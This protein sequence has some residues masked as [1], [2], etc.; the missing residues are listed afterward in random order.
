MNWQKI[1]KDISK[2][3]NS[4]NFTPLGIF[5]GIVGLCSICLL[6]IIGG[7]NNLETR[8]EPVSTNRIAPKTEVKT[9]SVQV[10]FVN[11]NGELLRQIDAEVADTP[12]ERRVGLMNREYLAPDKGMLFIFEN[13]SV[14]QFWMKNTLI[15]LDIIFISEQ[16]EIV[17]IH[18]NTIPNNTR[19]KYSSE[20]PIKYAI[21]VNAGFTNTSSIKEGDKI[22]F[23]Q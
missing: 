2:K 6:L 22:A 15:S 4:I 13:S 14:R 23:E 10:S 19:I 11:E 16:M 3:L 8:R 7:I 21:E 9:N 5:L 20:E 12:E 18:T 1:S 17:K